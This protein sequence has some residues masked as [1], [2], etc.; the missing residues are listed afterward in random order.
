[1]AHSITAVN[2]AGLAFE[3]EQDGHTF[4]LD[5]DPSAGGEDRG[6]QPKALLL[7]GLAGCTGMDVASIL[8]KMKMPYD[9]LTIQ[10]SA[11]LTNEHPRVYDRIRVKY[12]LAGDNL[13]RDKIEKAVALS[14]DKYCGVAAMLAKSAK[15]DY[16]IIA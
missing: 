1:M 15:I 16:E 2:S 12:I 11:D 3:I 8:G 5:A 13:D 4:T 10:V 9:K 6:P 14:R 7:S